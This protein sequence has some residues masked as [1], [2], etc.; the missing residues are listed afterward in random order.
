[1]SVER[2]F[3]DVHAGA[4]VRVLE[5][6]VTDDPRGRR[7]SPIAWAAAVAVRRCR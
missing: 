6:A 4:L 1:M 7:A 3:R 5:T 2:I